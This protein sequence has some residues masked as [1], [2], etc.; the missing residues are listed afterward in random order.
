M[1]GIKTYLESDDDIYF[2]HFL[3]C[4]LKPLVE[5]VSDDKISGDQD[6]IEYE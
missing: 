2:V 5:C 6:S 1:S 3:A 4:D